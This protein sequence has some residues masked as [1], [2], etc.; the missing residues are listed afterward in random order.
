MAAHEQIWMKVNVPVD[1][2]IAELVSVLNSIDGRSR[3]AAELPRRSW[4]A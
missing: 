3:D 2:G 1:R 4:R